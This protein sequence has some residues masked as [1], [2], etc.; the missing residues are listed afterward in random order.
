MIAITETNIDQD[1]LTE[2]VLYDV[3]RKMLAKK[4]HF[5]TYSEMYENM[6]KENGKGF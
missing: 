6:F 5:D 2:S 3:N 4:N 1:W